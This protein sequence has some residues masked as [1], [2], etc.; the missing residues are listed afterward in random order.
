MS[1]RVFYL[2]I[3]AVLATIATLSLT[4]EFGLEERVLPVFGF[5]HAAEDS[6][7]RWE[8]VVTTVAFAAIA[9]IGPTVVGAR[10]IRREHALREEVTRLS[11]EDDLTGLLNRRRISQLLDSEMRRA[12]RYETTF[13]VVMMDIDNFK[14]VNDRFGHLAGDAVLKRVADVLRSVVRST[15]LVGRWGGEEFIILLPETGIAGGISLAEKLRTQLEAVDFGGLGTRT[16]SFGVARFS[17]GDDVEA[18]IGRADAGLYA[19]KNAGKNQTMAAQTDDEVERGVDRY[20]P[21]K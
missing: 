21:P 8:F 11:Q 7:Q 10:M 20:G 4:W 3:L 1:L 15:D 13:S 16:A 12:L 14:A 2:V 19:A 18:L 6:A 17:P 9:L 5:G